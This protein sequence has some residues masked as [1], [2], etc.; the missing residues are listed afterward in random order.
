MHCMP[1]RCASGTTTAIGVGTTTETDTPVGTGAEPV[2]P[3]LLGHMHLTLRRSFMLLAPCA[4]RRRPSGSV[5][6]C[7]LAAWLTLHFKLPPPHHLLVQMVCTQC[8]GPQLLA[9]SR[10]SHMYRCARIPSER[11]WETHRKPRQ[12]VLEPQ[13]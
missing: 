12:S 1:R 7:L 4:G 13:P 3:C 11:C 2:A 6:F 9:V 10:R 8:H 5:A